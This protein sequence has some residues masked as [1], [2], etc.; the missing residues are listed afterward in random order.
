MKFS[1]TLKYE[2]ITPSFNHQEEKGESSSGCCRLNLS[3]SENKRK[4]KLQKYLDLARELEMLFNMNV[5]FILIV[6]GN[7]RTILKNL[8][9]RLDE[10]RSS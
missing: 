6:D 5:T 3:L 10:M 8:E 4:Q 9:K 7:R 1:G 2:P